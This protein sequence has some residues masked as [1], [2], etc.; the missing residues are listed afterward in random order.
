[1]SN[2][3]LHPNVRPKDAATLIVIDRSGASPKVLM[4]QRHLN[5]PFMP[6]KY[7]FPGGRVDRGDSRLNVPDR[8]HRSV[9]RKLLND[10]KGVASPRRAQA[11]ALAAIRETAEETGLL[12]GARAH[13]PWTTSSPAW[14]PFVEQGIAPSLSPLTFFLR[15]ITPPRQV[16]RFDTRFFCAPAEAIAHQLPN[17][18]DEL[19]N[20]HW[21]TFGQALELELPTIT[22][23]ALETLDAKLSRNEYPSP[24]DDI[25]YFYRRNGKFQREIL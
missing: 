1:M 21:L 22:R 13:A 11:L 6:G 23:F 9:E 15:A 16:R 5:S 20:L 2:P 17:E 10:M 4:G 14:Q 12:I 7:V 3:E 18:N 24:R 19:L 25:D 8:L